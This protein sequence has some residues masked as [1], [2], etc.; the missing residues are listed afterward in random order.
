VSV[1]C[2][3]RPQLEPQLEVGD[4]PQGAVFITVTDNGPGIDHEFLPRIFEKFEKS[5]FSSGTGLGLYMARMIIEALEGSL[6]VR[7]SS[8]GTTF[9]ISV[10]GAP[11]WDRVEA[12]T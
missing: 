10:P 2:S 11:A 1:G 6:S 12:M 4:R 3:T 5:G 7:T 9:Q 8:A